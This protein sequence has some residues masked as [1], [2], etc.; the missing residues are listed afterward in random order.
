MS[1]QPEARISRAI[2]Q[3]LK[4]EGI[5]AFKVHGGPTQMAGVPDILAC[6]EGVFVGFETKVPGER[7]NTSARQE[8]VHERIIMAGG[9][10]VVVCSVPEALE[11]VARIRANVKRAGIPRNYWQI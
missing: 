5:F 7:R 2:L 10:A 9:V 3:A 1:T 8:Y 6:V 4:R 11:H